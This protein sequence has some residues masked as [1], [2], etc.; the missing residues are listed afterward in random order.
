MC[1]IILFLTTLHDCNVNWCLFFLLRCM[2]LRARTSA[3]YT[4]APTHQQ[5]SY[6]GQSYLWLFHPWCLHHCNQTSNVVDQFW[7]AMHAMWDCELQEVLWEAVRCTV[8]WNQWDLL[9]RITANVNIVHIVCLIDLYQRIVSNTACISL[10]M[11][12]EWCVYDV[13]MMCVWCV[14]DVCMM[15]VWCVYDVCMMCVWCVYDVCMMCVW[16]VYDVCMM[17]VWCV[18]DVCMMC[19]WCVYDVC[20]MCVWWVYDVCMMYVWCVYDVCMMCVWCVYDV[21][22]MYVWCV[23]DVCM[24]CVWCV[25]DVCM[26]YNCTCAPY[27]VVRWYC[28]EEIPGISSG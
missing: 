26:M 23:Y 11:M 25:Y 12:C 22:M 1:V 2:P 16:C 10:C 3:G 24:M 14:Y 13:C 17:C 19:V 21:C 20:M 18:Y 8:R 6:L 15:C 27:E 7:V 9:H 5:Q 28:G 4:P